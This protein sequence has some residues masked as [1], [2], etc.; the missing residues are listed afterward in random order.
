[1]LDKSWN[2]YYDFFYSRST[3]QYFIIVKGVGRK[4]SE[5]RQW[6]KQD[7]KIAPLSFLLYFIS[8]MKVYE[9]PGGPWPLL[10][11]TDTHDIVVDFIFLN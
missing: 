1:L 9:N 2:S 10:P 4:N 6:K 3:I 8:I 11:A 7:Q 5:K